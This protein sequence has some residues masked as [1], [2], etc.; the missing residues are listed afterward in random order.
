MPGMYS[1]GE[2]DLAGFIVGI[3]E[4]SKVIN[5][6]NVQERDMVI[7]LPSS[8]LHSNGFSLVRKIFDESYNEFIPLLGCTV[9]EEL[10]KPTKIYVNEIFSILD[11]VNVH[12]LVHI[13]GGGL[14]DNP[15]R[16]IPKN[17]A[18]R[19][20]RDI[21][22][23]PNI[24]ALIAHRGNVSEMEMYRT[25]NMGL[26]FL[27]VVPLDETYAVLNILKDSFVVGDIISRVNDSVEFI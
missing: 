17:L 8:G 3:V 7:A 26:G 11:S 27:I 5:G 1:D 16:V 22:D 10:L 9:G 2:Y 20:F 15:P 24:M 12:A 23:M 18:F 4:S 13:T 21:W 19:F 6:N 25:F 14:I